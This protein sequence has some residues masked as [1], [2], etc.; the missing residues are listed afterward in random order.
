MV[1]GVSLPLLVCVE[2]HVVCVLDPPP[3]QELPV[4]LGEHGLS[5]T[6]IHPCS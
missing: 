6:Y 5:T 3:V 4:A 2:H 1:V